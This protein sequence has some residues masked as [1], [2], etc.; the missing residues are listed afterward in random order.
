[1]KEKK[2]IEFIEEH[3]ICDYVFDKEQK[4]IVPVYDLRYTLSGE[5]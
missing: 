5:K 3:K 1:M 2:V 4:K